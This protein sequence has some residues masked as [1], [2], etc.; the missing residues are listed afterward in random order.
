MSRRK[1][2]RLGAFGRPD[3]DDAPAAQSDKTVSCGEKRLERD[4]ADSWNLAI[5]AEPLER[6]RG[7]PF[8][9]KQ[10]CAGNVD[11]AAGSAQHHDARRGVRASQQRP[12]NATGQD[13]FRDCPFAHP[14]HHPECRH[15]VAGQ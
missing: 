6:E 12:G 1:Q 10:L 7:R 14:I 8:P 2:G 3:I 15:G 11:A 5:A 9:G 4:L 13:F